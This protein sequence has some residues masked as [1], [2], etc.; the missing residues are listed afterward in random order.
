MD[1]AVT[2][3][4]KQILL[5]EDDE[6]IRQLYGKILTTAGYEVIEAPDGN[7]AFKLMHE[8]GYDL[9]LLDI[10]LPGM[11]GLDILESLTQTPPT[12]PLGAV[13]VLTNLDQDTTIAKGLSY[14]VRGYLIKSQVTPDIIRREVEAALSKAS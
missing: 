8:G 13:I 12:K 1:T 6:L 7:I 3:S 14:G 9:V 10:M 4:K 2:T 5:V 11:N